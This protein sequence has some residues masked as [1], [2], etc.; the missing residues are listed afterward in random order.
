[1]FYYMHLS[2]EWRRLFDYFLKQFYRF[3]FFLLG[4]FVKLREKTWRGVEEG[5]ARASLRDQKGEP[6]R[7][8]RPRAVPRA[9]PEPIRGRDLVNA[10]IL[11][12]SSCA[13]SRSQIV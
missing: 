8:R 9:P 11:P 12:W 13:I 2:K 1:M 6:Q 4:K 7:P 10:L 5:Q 3:C